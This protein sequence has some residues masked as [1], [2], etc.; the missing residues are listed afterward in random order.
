[1]AATG[2][3]AKAS[4]NGGEKSGSAKRKPKRSPAKKAQA[5][6]PPA[7]KTYGTSLFCNQPLT[8]DFAAAVRD[9]ETALGRPVWLCIQQG[10]QEEAS[11]GPAVLQMFLSAREILAAEGPV[12]L[13]LESPGGY[14][15]EAFKLARV[16]CRHSGGFTAVVPRYAKSAATLL[17]LGAEAILMGA[18]AEMGPLDAQLWDKEREERSSALDEVQALERLPSVALE[19]LDQTMM[20]MLTG[21]RKRTEVLLP[22]ACGFVAEMMAPL[23]DKI[24]TVHYAKQSRVLKVAQD[25]AERLLGPHHGPARTKFIADKLVNK[26]PEHGFVIDREEMGEL[27]GRS[28]VPSDDAGDAIRRLDE[29]LAQPMPLVAIGKLEER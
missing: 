3:A 11:L 26:Y 15:Q 22:I 6:E 25:Y 7:P 21:A 12:A 17:A 2:T 1:M 29:L 9:L 5:A 24:D 16:L 18:D 20:V 8:E 10:E 14:A 23:L 19:Q 13:V 4:Q 27:M 28:L